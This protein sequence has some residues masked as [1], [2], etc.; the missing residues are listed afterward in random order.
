MSE[1]NRIRPEHARARAAVVTSPVGRL[2][3]VAEGD[4]LV[5]LHWG[6]SDLPEATADPLLAEARDQLAAYFAGRLTRFTLPLAPRGSP[7]MRQVWDALLTIPYGRTT[8]Y[9]ALAATVGSTARAVGRAVG[10]NPIPI[11]IPCHRVLGADGRLTGYSGAG[12]LATK[13]RLLIHEGALL[14]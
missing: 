8:T 7:F 1:A 11:V 13:R 9:G 2:V 4:A 12:G 14:C 5:R 3:L 10:A 6:E